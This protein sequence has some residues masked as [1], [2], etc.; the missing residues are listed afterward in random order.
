M[1]RSHQ[2]NEAGDIIFKDGK[3]QR[4]RAVPG[5]QMAHQVAGAQKQNHANA[6]QHPLKVMAKCV[7]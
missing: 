6:G 4:R 2:K 7:G 3:V 5:M 1:P